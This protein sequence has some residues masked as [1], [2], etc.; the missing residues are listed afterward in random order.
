MESSVLLSSICPEVVLKFFL[1]LSILF[2]SKKG[3][4]E[5]RGNE[6]REKREDEKGSH[7]FFLKSSGYDKLEL[8]HQNLVF[9]SLIIFFRRVFSECTEAISISLIH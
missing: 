3:G 1:F 6:E 9:S 8:K 5:A 4:R 7:C 2:K